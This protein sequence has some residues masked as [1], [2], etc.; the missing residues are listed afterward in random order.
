[1]KHIIFFL[2]FIFNLLLPT[3]ALAVPHPP[4]AH[5][6]F[7]LHLKV[8]DPNTLL[9]TWKIKPNFFLYRNR[10]K[11]IPLHDE[12][13]DL[14]DMKFP[15]AQTKTDNLNQTVLIY[16]DRLT[17]SLGLVA[18]HPGETI[19]T[20]Y[21]QGC[22]DDGFCYPPESRSIKLTIN[23]HLALTHAEL[24]TPISSKT[25]STPSPLFTHHHWL[26]TLLIFSG[27]GLLLSFTPCVLPMIPV[28]SSIYPLEKLFSFH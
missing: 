14:A 4:P 28:L 18:L 27:L 9:L 1:M 2:F 3:T 23:T 17:L 16:R 22:A 7:Q 15:P 20:I 10:I 11:I 6:A 25:A 5:A 19:V 8:H 26:I 12:M 13:L 21:F 24:I